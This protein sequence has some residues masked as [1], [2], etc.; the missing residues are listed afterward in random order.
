[1]YFRNVFKFF[2]NFFFLYFL[3]VL[4]VLFC[5]WCFV[6]HA[7]QY[8]QNFKLWLRLGKDTNIQ[9]NINWLQW[10]VLFLMHLKFNTVPDKLQNT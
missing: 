10:T 6:K 9:A 5:F 3:P 7:G 8:K 1:M 4:C 2:Q